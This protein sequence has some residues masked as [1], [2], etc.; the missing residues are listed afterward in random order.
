ME[1]H[2]RERDNSLHA[3]YNVKNR[4][5][6]KNRAEARRHLE[7]AKLSNE[8][9][10]RIGGDKATYV[11]KRDDINGLIEMEPTCCESFCKFIKDNQP[12]ISVICS[13]I[14]VCLSISSQSN[15]MSVPQDKPKQS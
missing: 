13:V 12:T 9:F 5:S 8:K 10:R 7:D 11:E 14:T 15:F 1:E 3:Y 2:E 4:D 6:V